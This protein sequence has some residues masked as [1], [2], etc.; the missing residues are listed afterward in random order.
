MPREHGAWGMLLVPFATAAATAGVFDAKVMLLLVSTLCFYIAR[1]SWLKRQF[2]WMALLLAASLALAAPLLLVWKLWWLAAFSIVAAG[3]AAR[4]NPRSLAMQL[5]A[6]AGL[7]LTAPAAWYAATG[8]LDATA[9]WLWLWNTLYFAGGVLYVRLR[10]ERSGPR[11]PVLAFYGAVLLF[12][13]ALALTD[14]VSSRVLLAFAPA[15]ARAAIGVG[16]LASPLRVKRLG[17][18]EVA[19]SL[20]F[21]ALL[22]VALR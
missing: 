6:T 2:K 4:P 5:A 3:L 11:W 10:I 8:A 9:F 19:H 1:T 12:V 18:S 17:W 20:V 22:T 13:L 21:G 7:T 14:V 15:A 16:R